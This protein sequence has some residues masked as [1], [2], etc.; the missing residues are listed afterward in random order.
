M[1]RKSNIYHTRIFGCKYF[2]LNNGKVQLGKFDPKMDKA[3]FLGLCITNHI[4]FNERTL[5]VEES[6]HIAFD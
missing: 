1:S 5:V 4:V 2:V 6:I 3:I